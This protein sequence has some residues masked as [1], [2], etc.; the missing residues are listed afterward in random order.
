MRASDASQR[1]A[2]ARTLGHVFA[3]RSAL[4]Y[5]VHNRSAAAAA[6]GDS[7]QMEI[8]RGLLLAKAQ[9]DARD[10]CRRTPLHYAAAGGLCDAGDH[11]IS[12]EY[13]IERAHTAQGLSDPRAARD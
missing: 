9:V 8:V 12:A 1:H 2:R 6:G 11:P 13:S 5:A 3:G 10:E 7:V 4:H